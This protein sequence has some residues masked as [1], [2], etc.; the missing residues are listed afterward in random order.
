AGWIQSIG[1][2]LF[3]MGLLVWMLPLLDQ[4]ENPLIKFFRNWY[5]IF[6]FPFLYWDVGGYIQLV[7][8]QLF[9]PAILKLEKTLFGVLPNIWVQQYVSPV[10]TEIM[11]ISY[12]IYWLT[13]PMGAAIFYF[14]RE[15][16]LFNELLRAI[17]FTFFL[18]YFIFIFFPVA[19]PRFFLADRITADYHSYFVGN[20]LRSFV[21]DAGFRGGAFPSSHVAVAVVILLFVW[22]FRPNTAILLFLPM[23]IALSLSTVYGQYH[24]AVDVIAGLLLGVVL[25]LAAAEWTAG[26]LGK[27]NGKNSAY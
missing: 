18:C 15:L 17:T 21:K 8:P 19:G 20:F 10:L 27:Q 14:R 5:I 23:V 25:G 9:D 22:R 11:Q 6:A 1:L 12:G 24:Y 13:I 26:R 16:F 3:L 4:S 7:F 2:H